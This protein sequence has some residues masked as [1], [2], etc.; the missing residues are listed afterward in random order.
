[1]LKNIV[2]VGIV[3]GPLLVIVSVFMYFSKLN[4]TTLENRENIKKNGLNI[5]TLKFNDSVY[6]VTTKEFMHLDSLQLK[7]SQDNNKMLH[8]LLKRKK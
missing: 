5:D 1:M 7:V 3:V 8:K 4:K 2:K 6:Q